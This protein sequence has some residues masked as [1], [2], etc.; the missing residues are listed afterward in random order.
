MEIK[1]Y[2]T[3][4]T[5]YPT[6]IVLHCDMDRACRA[7][8]THVDSEGYTYCAKHGAQRRGGGIRCRHLT[9]LEAQDL[10]DG[11]VIRY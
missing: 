3:A 4:P 7:D 6:P 1:F 2:G 11:N 8:V 9:A 5:V 10:R